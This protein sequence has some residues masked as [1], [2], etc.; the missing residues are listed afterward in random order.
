MNTSQTKNNQKYPQKES[1]LH[2]E[3]IRLVAD[4]GF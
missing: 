3:F 2:L 4:G 1:N